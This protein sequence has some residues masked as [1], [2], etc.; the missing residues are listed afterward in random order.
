VTLMSSIPTLSSNL[1]ASI[2]GNLN[3]IAELH[4]EILGDL[5]RVVPHSEYTQPNGSAEAKIST[6][7]SGHN[8]WRSLDAVPEHA[9]GPNWLQKIPGMIAEPKVA[10]EVARIFGNKV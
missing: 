6:P 8:R 1:R 2:N 5:H 7:A 9:G 3:E 4:E 10:A